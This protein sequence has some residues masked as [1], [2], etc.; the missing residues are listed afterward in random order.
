MKSVSKTALN[1]TTA[2]QAI[3]TDMAKASIKGHP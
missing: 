2:R 1:V 3:T